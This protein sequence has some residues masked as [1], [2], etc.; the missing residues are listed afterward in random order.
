MAK[1]KIDEATSA[2]K[3]FSYLLG[4]IE[5]KI[6][7]EVK[8]FRDEV[9]NEVYLSFSRDLTKSEVKEIKRMLLKKRNTSISKIE[10]AF[11]SIF[12][13][14]LLYLVIKA[15][16]K[17]RLVSFSTN[18]CVEEYAKVLFELESQ[19]LRWINEIALKN[20]SKFNSANLLKD[21][22]TKIFKIDAGLKFNLGGKNFNVEKYLQNRSKVIAIDFLNNSYKCEVESNNI[23]IVRFVRV[24]AAKEPRAH[25]KFENKLFNLK[26]VGVM[27]KNEYVLPV[28]YIDDYTPFNPPY[29]CGHTLEAVGRV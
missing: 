26:D 5:N 4:E 14:L 18:K 3:R 20:I 24:E 11:I 28:S 10:E 29:G 12:T 23:N 2:E 16:W 27:Y 17:N 8:L 22:K 15:S 1:I 7:T 9:R 19:G 21:L 6:N 13:G 25:S